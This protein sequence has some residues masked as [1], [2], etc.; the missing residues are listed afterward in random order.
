MT[1]FLL[2]IFDQKSLASVDYVNTGRIPSLT[3]LQRA[4]VAYLH[5]TLHEVSEI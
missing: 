5:G 4:E 2:M 3:A 1:C